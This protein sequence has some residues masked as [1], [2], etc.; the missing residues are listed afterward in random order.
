M[1]T[2]LATVVVLVAQLLFATP[3]AAEPDVPSTL[4]G[5]WEGE[6]YIPWDRTPPGRILEVTSVVQQNGVWVVKGARYGVTGRR[7]APVDVKIEQT[8]DKIVLEFRTGA[9][10]LVQLH[11]K[12]KS[13]TPTLTG[14]LTTAGTAQSIGQPYQM[15]LEKKR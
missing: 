8:Q 15:V 14:T 10:S 4:V 9:N 1:R 6:V 11:L 2:T 3:V 12:L 7:M 5:T 13:S